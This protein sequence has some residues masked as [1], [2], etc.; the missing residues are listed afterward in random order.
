MIPAQ[1]VPCPAASPVLDGLKVT[2]PAS[3][4]ASTESLTFPFKAGCCA[5]IPLSTTPTRTPRPVRPSHTISGVIVSHKLGSAPFFSFRLDFA[6]RAATKRSVILLLLTDKERS[7]LLYDAMRRKK[8]DEGGGMGDEGKT[9]RFVRF[10]SL[11][12]PPSSLSLRGAW[13]KRV[14][15]MTRNLARPASIRVLCKE[16]ERS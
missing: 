2:R 1:A 13:E 3:T 16:P 4:T 5:S 9:M 15:Q 7:A 11:L 10:S 8:R 14:C 12:P 6:I